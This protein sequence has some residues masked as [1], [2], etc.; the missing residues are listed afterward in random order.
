MKISIIGTGYVGLVAAACFADRGFEVITSS[1][2]EDK[3]KTINEGKAPFYEKGLDEI[4]ERTVKKGTLKAVV[5]REE[6]ILDSDISFIAVGTPSLP[7]GSADLTFIKQTASE[8]GKALKQR[9]GYHVV[10]ARSTIVPGTTRTVIKPLVEEES[11]KKAGSDFGLCMSPEFLRQGDAVYDTLY[12]DRLVVGEFDKRSGDV[13]YDFYEQF[14]GKDSFPILRMN[15]ES[16][17]MV[18]YASNSFLATK[19]SFINEIASICE[20][21]AGVDVYEV[22]KGV[23]LDSRISPKFLRAGPGFGGSCFPKDVK[24][25]IAFAKERNYEPKLLDEVLDKN[26]KQAMHVVELAESALGTLQNKTI[27][28]LGLSFKKNTDDMRESPS[29]KIINKL[30]EKGATVKAFDPYAE[31]TAKIVL[32]DRIMYAASI[33]DCLKNSDCAMLVTD[34]EEFESVEP[35]M[36]KELMREPFVI[37]ARP[38]KINSRREYRDRFSK[39]VKYQTIGLK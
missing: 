2:D 26:I 16:A 13:L 35:K 4:V 33:E 23:G 24:A 31:G 25:L 27:S 5:G 14:Y 7:D 17:E 29:T 20:T 12:P 32:G 38:L 18:K 30:L 34:W 11:G 39:F 1:H 15:M 36:F 8:I 37:D 10:V 9:S 6:A 28:L 22:A 3:V 21:M 19:I